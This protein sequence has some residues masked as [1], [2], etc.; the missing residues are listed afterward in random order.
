[1]SK[2]KATNILDWLKI[3]GPAT[4]LGLTALLVAYQFVD[5]APPTM[6]TIATGAPEG[7]Y[8]GHAERYRDS[9]EQHGITLDIR[10][11][12]GSIENLRL[13]ADATVDVAFVQGGTEDPAQEGLYS[14]GSLYFEPLWLFYRGDQ[15]LERLGDLRQRRL[16]VG[17]PGSGTHALAQA[18]LEQ[19]QLKEGALELVTRGGR[20]AVEALA[21]GEIDAA[22][23]V[24]GADAPIITELIASPGIR[25]MSFRRA[26]AY[27]ALL[28]YLSR[29]VLVEGMID[30]VRNIPTEDVQLLAPTAQLVV[31]A[32]LHPALQDLLMQTLAEVHGKGDWIEG[33]GR[34]PSPEFLVFPLSPEAR[35]YY[36]HGAPFLQR[37][38]PFWAATLL[39]RLKVMLVPLLV[40]LLP[41]LR[42]M[43]PLYS[44]R[45]RAKIFRWY[46]ALETVEDNAVTGLDDAQLAENLK[47][48]DRIEAEV[49]KV[50]VPLSFAG[51]AYDLRMH[52]RLVRDTL[53]KQHGK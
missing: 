9:L 1:M 15:T 52:L 18:L 20:D 21:A 4:V 14:L 26:R 34:F 11:T 5:P 28:P 16:A 30:L 25:L 31:S 39:D 19:N 42:F 41:L 8:A 35:R 45:M 3:Y 23:F 29:V 7:A 38:L 53:R 33:A 27:A 2:R 22:F 10:H 49:R 32:D 37:Y 13:L 47:E 6:I 46:K 48:L 24:S 43:P 12:Q 51:Q 44:W 17:D 40:V 36:K 50:E